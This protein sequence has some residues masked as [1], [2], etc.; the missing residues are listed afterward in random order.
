MN[1]IKIAQININV[2][3]NKEAEIS[4]FLHTSQ[5]DILAINETKLRKTDSLHFPG[6]TIFRK[7]RSNR[8][9]GGGL[10]TDIKDNID[11]TLLDIPRHTDNETVSTTI[12]IDQNFTLLLTNI[13]I[14]PLTDI[15]PNYMQNILKQFKHHIILGDFN[16]KHPA[17]CNHGKNRSGEILSQLVSDNNLI[18]LNNDQPTHS[19]I[20]TNTYSENI[21]DLMIVTPN[22]TKRFLSFHVEEDLSSD[23][24]PITATFQREPK[25]SKN[26]YELISYPHYK[27]TNW[28]MVATSTHTWKNSPL[29]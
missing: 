4:N 24:L 2:I 28:K 1:Q 27:N 25:N 19:T 3:R 15:D 5:I 10:A 11:A 9:G 6:Y 26:I 17:L 12:K 20:S 23:H 7:E 22:V 18:L 13:Y 14:P 8:P 29:Q 21:L 16:A